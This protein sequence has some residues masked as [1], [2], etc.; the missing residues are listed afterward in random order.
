MQT[1]ELALISHL[2]KIWLLI[3][4]AGRV[5]HWHHHVLAKHGQAAINLIFVRLRAIA[6]ICSCRFFLN[7]QRLLVSKSGRLLLLKS[8]VLIIVTSGCGTSFGSDGL[9]IA[10][11]FLLD[12]FRLWIEL[13]ANI[14]CKINVLNT[15]IP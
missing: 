5:G 15:T 8:C 12:P 11:F 10:D 13:K 1:F 2:S 6:H 4:I 14:S 3:W 9:G 7:Y